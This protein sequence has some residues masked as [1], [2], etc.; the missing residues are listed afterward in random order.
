MQAI[1]AAPICK[2][3][4]GNNIFPSY[5]LWQSLLSWTRIIL[6][7]SFSN[8]TFTIK[9]GH[10]YSFL[11]SNPLSDRTDLKPHAQEV[12]S[13]VQPIAQHCTHSK[14]ATTKKHFDSRSENSR[15]GEGGRTMELINS[16]GHLGAF[17]HYSRASGTK[18]SPQQSPKWVATYLLT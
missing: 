9:A 16:S 11:I 4:N 6:H 13:L 7:K 2:L 3:W 17:L 10:E 18:P 12:Q 1:S 14:T 15:R 5:D 8:D